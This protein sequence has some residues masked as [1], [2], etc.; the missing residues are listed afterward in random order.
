MTITKN[1]VYGNKLIMELKYTYTDLQNINKSNT[2]VSLIKSFHT[3]NNPLYVYNS[4]YNGAY[5]DYNYNNSYQAIV[6]GTSKYHK[7]YKT[8]AHELGHAVGKFQTLDIEPTHQTAQAFSDARRIGEGEAIFYEFK[9]AHE[10]EGKNFNSYNVPLWKKDKIS[11]VNTELFNDI[12]KII[13]RNTVLT[14]DLAKKIGQFNYDMESSGQQGFSNLNLTYDEEDKAYFVLE[15][16]NFHNEY[17]EVVG[18]DFFGEVFYNGVATNDYTNYIQLKSLFNRYNNHYNPNAD[19]NKDVSDELKN[20]ANGSALARQY[21]EYDLLYGGKGKDTLTGGSNKDILLGGEGNDTL[22]GNAGTDILGGNAGNDTLYGGAGADKLNGGKGKDTYHILDHDTIIDSDKSGTVYFEKGFNGKPI[23]AQ[24]FIAISKDVWLST[25][26]QNKFYGEMLATRQGNHLSITTN[27]HSVVIN[28]FFGA[29]AKKNANTLSWNGLDISLKDFAFVHPKITKPTSTQKN[30]TLF[31]F[32]HEYINKLSAT[33]TEAQ[34]ETARL[35]AATKNSGSETDDMLMSTQNGGSVVF[36]NGGN[37]LAYGG[38]GYDWLYG[39]LG[40]DMLIGSALAALNSRPDKYGLKGN[41]ALV[42]THLLDR[43]YLVGGAGSDLIFG[44]DGN[45]VIFT[46]E[47]GFEKGKIAGHL[48]PENAKESHKRGDLAAGGKGDDMIYG[49]QMR[50]LLSGGAGSDTIFGGAGRDVLVG[51]GEFFPEIK[52]FYQVTA[53]EIND[54]NQLSEDSSIFRV[55]HLDFT[56]SSA[57]FANPKHANNQNAWDFQINTTTHQF[58]YQNKVGIRLGEHSVKIGGAS[59][60]LFGGIGDDLLIGQFGND[61]LDGGDGN[62]YLW[63]DDYLNK[64]ISGNDTLKGGAGSNV[65][66]GGKGDD[67]YIFT[68]ADLK[69]KADKNIIRDEDGLGKIIIDGIALHSIAWKADPKNTNTHWTDAKTGLD[70]RLANGNLTVSS[71]KF[72]AKITIENFKNGVLGL[73]LLAAPSA[74]M[75]YD[76]ESFVYATQTNPQE[77]HL[78]ENQII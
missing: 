28:D 68:S 9:V 54:K 2:L 35:A 77:I 29:N 65:L 58:K 51:D 22:H 53:N 11:S 69:N 40:N 57:E 59:D 49:S 75:I 47:D 31:R 74:R 78:H 21:D 55:Q 36:L 52:R 39:G 18:S 46:D 19:V 70:L 64:A 62:D 48:Q 61:Y 56:P 5:Y 23:Q 50:D 8:L 4:S 27:S 72:A 45:D 30:H 43:D 60:Y 20:Y 38:Y 71:S 25:N 34:H 7:S 24:S 10:L 17:R 42:P 73:K 12:N 37:D 66:Y 67:S 44:V 13:G 33:A 6:V 16:T 14:R 63:G 1:D 32:T 3:L 41:E 26:T 76:D 15:K